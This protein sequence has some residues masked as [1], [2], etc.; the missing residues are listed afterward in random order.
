M[1]GTLIPG[2]LGA[3]F[4][5]NDLAASSTWERQYVFLSMFP[6]II[7]PIFIAYYVTELLDRVIGLKCAC[8]QTLSFGSHVVPLMKHGGSC[9]Q[10]GK[11]AVECTSGQNIQV[12][13]NRR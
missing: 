4:L 2:V 5:T 8:G 12:E 13:G 1:F 3:L 11:I 9:P 7:T 10:C 6:A